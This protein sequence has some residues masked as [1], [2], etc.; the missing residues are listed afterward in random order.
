MDPS[1]AELTGALQVFRR[2]ASLSDASTNGP[3]SPVTNDPS[4]S[5]RRTYTLSFVILVALISFLLGSLLRSLL[6]PADYIIYRNV[7]PGGQQVERALMQAFDPQRK[8]REAK[9][10]IE[11]RP[12]WFSSWDIIVAAV[13]RV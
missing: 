11:V 4:T 7:Q 9:R 6:T 10:L 8:W 13:K 5:K 2:E 3:T 12:L 1:T